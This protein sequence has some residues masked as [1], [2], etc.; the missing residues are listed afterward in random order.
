MEKKLAAARAT[1]AAANAAKAAAA[2]AKPAEPETVA[3]GFGELI[4][5][6]K[7]ASTAGATQAGGELGEKQTMVEVGST[8]VGATANTLEDTGAPEDA[9][10]A[11]NARVAGLLGK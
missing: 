3:T 5:P 10:E 1:L 2:A 6:N 11:L 9:D 8:S 4:L 7:T